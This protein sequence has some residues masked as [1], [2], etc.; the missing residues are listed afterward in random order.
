MWLL[1]AIEEFV[2]VRSEGYK[3]KPIKPW[4]FSFCVRFVSGIEN[5]IRKIRE[6]YIAIDILWYYFYY[7]GNKIFCNRSI[8]SAVFCAKQECLSNPPSLLCSS[9]S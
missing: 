6:N 1:R 7:L 9:N 5:S 3:I 2:Y 4:F 8:N